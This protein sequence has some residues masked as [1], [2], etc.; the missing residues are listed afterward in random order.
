MV[1]NWK[2]CDVLPGNATVISGFWIL[3]LDLFG[4]SL[5][6]NVISHNTL[7]VTVSILRFFFTGWRLVSF[8]ARSP[9][10]LSCLRASAASII[11]CYCIHFSSGTGWELIWKWLH[12]ELTENYSR[13]A[14]NITRVMLYSFL[15]G[16]T[17]NYRLI[18]QKTPP[19]LL[20]PVC[21][22]IA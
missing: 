6:G 19:L 15:T 4:L 20:K 11:H 18:T 10:S 16:H 3:H 21:R 12:L 14:P 22:I 9:N 13:T 8:S 2:Y 17:E 1:W 5:C 7:N